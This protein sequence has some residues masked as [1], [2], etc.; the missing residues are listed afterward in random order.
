MRDLGGGVG[1]DGSRVWEGGQML[2][3]GWWAGSTFENDSVCQRPTRERL[4]AK[5][6]DQGRRTLPGVVINVR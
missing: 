2:T 1:I 5:V 4:E 3:G 6:R